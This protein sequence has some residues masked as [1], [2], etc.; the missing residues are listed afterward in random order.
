MEIDIKRVKK[1]IA[2]QLE[3]NEEDFDVEIK[4]VK[5]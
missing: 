4:E 3:F 1:D 5:K 2:E